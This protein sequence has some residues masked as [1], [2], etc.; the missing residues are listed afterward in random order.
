MFGLT[1]HIVARFP[2]ILH[3]ETNLYHCP[4]PSGPFPRTNRN[5]VSAL[6]KALRAHHQPNQSHCKPFPLPT[7]DLV[8]T[9]LMQIRFP[10][11]PATGPALPEPR[12]M[13]VISFNKCAT[14]LVPLPLPLRLPP[15]PPSRSVR[16]P[17][18]IKT[19]T[20]ESKDSAP[21]GELRNSIIP[22]RGRGS[23]LRRNG[24]RVGCV[25]EG[26]P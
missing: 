9:S 14:T 7:L 19:F 10:L 6:N 4:N 17:L 22:W 24:W 26:G 8:I 12:G 20:A 18:E 25:K 2:I 1:T 11:F 21:D 5:E 13:R 3:S 23:R 15:L 16:R